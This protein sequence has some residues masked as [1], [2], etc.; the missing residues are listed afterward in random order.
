MVAGV[1]QLIQAKELKKAEVLNNKLNRW[2]PVYIAGDI[3]T[4]GYTALQGVTLC[5]PFLA[6]LTAMKI[7]M[8]ACGVVGGAINMG[9]G[10]MCGLEGAQALKNGQKKLSARLGIDCVSF[11]F[12]GAIMAIIGLAPYVHQFQGISSALTKEAWLLPTLFTVVSIPMLIELVDK[13]RERRNRSDV[14]RKLIDKKIK[15]ESDYGSKMETM[16]EAVGVEAA[17]EVMKLAENPDSTQQLEVVKKKLKAW[18]F[19]INVRMGQQ[20]FFIIAFAVSLIGLSHIKGAKDFTIGADFAMAAGN[21]IPTYMDIFWP[22]RRN[23][24]MVVPKVEDTN[25]PK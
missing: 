25:D 13:I 1:S 9:V 19:S 15:L 7:A 6:H 16:Q 14:A 12:I 5:L 11:L 10:G 8:C 23:T 24:P 22:F 4:V 21:F 3:L 18:D 2:N 20:I 17:I